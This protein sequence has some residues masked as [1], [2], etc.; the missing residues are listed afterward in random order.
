MT[1]E[2]P[3]LHS[4]GYQGRSGVHTS[5]IFFPVSLE[6]IVSNDNEAHLACSCDIV[7]LN[8]LLCQIL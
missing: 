1:N 7:Y 4:V 3:D 8:V 6:E 5:P 2:V